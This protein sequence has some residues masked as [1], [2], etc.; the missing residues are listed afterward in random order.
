[1]VMREEID[2]NGLKGFMGKITYGEISELTLLENFKVPDLSETIEN[3]INEY[4][5]I[6]SIDYEALFFFVTLVKTM[7]VKFAPYVKN[8][9]IESYKVV[10]VT[11]SKI[12]IE[13][14]FY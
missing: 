5:S 13:Y 3:F 12:I 1:M 4:E 8:K 14:K 9:V 2:I 11:D 6:Y 10:M 7:L